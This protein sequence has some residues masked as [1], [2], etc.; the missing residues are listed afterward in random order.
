MKPGRVVTW[1]FG[2]GKPAILTTNEIVDN[3]FS[4]EE[5]KEKTFTVTMKAIEKGCSI[6]KQQKVY[7]QPNPVANFELDEYTLNQYEPRIIAINKSIG[8][9]K[10]RWS[11]GDGT[12]P[13][14]TENIEHV[15]EVK[16]G[17]YNVQLIA[18]ANGENCSDTMI[19][20]VSIPDEPIY[21]VPN[22]FTPNNDRTNNV[23]TPVFSSGYDPQ[24]YS[25]QVF[26]R[27]G[28]MIFE[29]RNPAIGWDGTYA[30]DLVAN[31]VYV[32]KIEFKEKLTDKKHQKYGNVNLIK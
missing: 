15:Y 26:D 8:A 6:S 30:G 4:S 10:Y 12:F 28:E 9:T 24:H 22:T 2:N 13:V 18:I 16:P 31:D 3:T 23:F 7:L 5:L 21:Y 32:W 20:R 25:F 17:D 19:R 1:D 11:F 14:S 27:W 29:S